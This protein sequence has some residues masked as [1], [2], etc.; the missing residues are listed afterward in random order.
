MLR[1]SPQSSALLPLL[2][3]VPTIAANDGLWS[4]VNCRH[5]S[6]ITFLF[7][8]VLRGR[9]DRESH[10]ITGAGGDCVDELDARQ[11]Q[12]G[13]QAGHRRAA[14]APGLEG[15]RD[16]ALYAGR[17]EGES[18]RGHFRSGAGHARTASTSTSMAT[19]APPDGTS[20]GGHYNPE[21]HRHAGPGTSPRARRRPGQR[22]GRRRGQSAPGADGGEHQ[23]GRS[24][25]P[26]HRARRDPPREGRRPEEPADRRRRAGASPAA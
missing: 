21:G 8:S 23:R 22:S 24:E 17:R 20:A 2:A 12:R 6:T 4:V 16:R 25:E 18:R 1:T 19:A 14:S 9:S 10:S 7:S 5:C 11:Q 3:L 15:D 13:D 26:H